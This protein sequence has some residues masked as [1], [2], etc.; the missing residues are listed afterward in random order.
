[1]SVEARPLLEQLLAYAE[2]AEAGTR[3]SAARLTAKHLKSY[4]KSPS[5]T[6]REEFEGLMMAAEH[7]GAVRLVRK[8]GLREGEIEAISLESLDRLAEFL[9]RRTRA[10]E[11]E[12]A[13][14]ILAPWLADFPALVDVLEHWRSLR[15]ARGTS[16]GRARDWADA[17]HV[18]R[19]MRLNAATEA[20]S[21]PVRE[22]SARLFCDSKRIE[23]ITPLID[24]LLTEDITA[25]RRPPADVWAEIGLRREEQPVRL[26]GRVE[27]ERDR[28][29]ALL[30]VPYGAFPPATVRGVRGEVREILT[31]ENL[32]TF[33]TEAAAR[34][35]E[36][37]LILYTA[38][39]PAPAWRAMYMR[40][41]TSAPS[42]AR[43]L[44]WGD[45]D[46]GGFRIAAQIAAVARAAGRR[47]DPYRMEPELVS[48]P[49]RRP[50]SAATCERMRLYARRAGWPELGERVASAGFTVEQESLERNA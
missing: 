45:V 2:K 38:G 44:H 40:L 7:A 15:P 46:E 14:A 43:L 12:E 26:A 16:P 41:I 32:T 37:V 39:M 30:D 6:A 49:A 8:H 17:V 31:I 5:L 25:G 24:A 9:G 4:Q 29:T 10:A 50:A 36:P 33:H 11:L 42:G 13:R 27:I 28:V 19:S 21:L 47:L 35:D 22:V 20:V 18:V 48:E 23:A 3:A 34:C 1:M